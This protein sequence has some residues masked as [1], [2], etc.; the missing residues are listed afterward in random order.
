MKRGAHVVL[1]P[2]VFGEDSESDPP[3]CAAIHREM[4]AECAGRLQLL[5]GAYDAQEIK[6]VIGR[7]DFFLGSRMHAC[8]AA[9]SQ[10]VPAIG[11]AYSRKFRGVFQSIGVEELAIDL[12]ETEAASVL[13]QVES[14]YESRDRIRA[15]L[16]KFIPGARESVLNVFSECAATT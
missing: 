5:E 12:H 10:G 16:H 1:V 15:R 14:A 7:C 9:L 8:I 3:A 6:H 11:L 13:D 4:V 2:H